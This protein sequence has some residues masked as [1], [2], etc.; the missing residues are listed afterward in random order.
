MMKKKYGKCK[1][2]NRR[3]KWRHDRQNWL[4]ELLAYPSKQTYNK[5][6]VNRNWCQK[7]VI[8]FFK[9]I[10]NLTFFQNSIQ[11]SVQSTTVVRRLASDWCRTSAD[12][13]CTLVQCSLCYHWWTGGIMR[14]WR[15]YKKRIQMEF[16]TSSLRSKN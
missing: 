3:V 13:F 8:F 1:K 14:I 6:Y 4:F 9:L 2:C 12:A 10:W 11:I 7:S 15:V 5:D 16:I